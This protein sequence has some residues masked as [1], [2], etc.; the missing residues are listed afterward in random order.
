MSEAWHQHMQNLTWWEQIDRF[1][2][3]SKYTCSTF[4]TTFFLDLFPI[5][6]FFVVFAV[7]LAW[8]FWKEDEKDEY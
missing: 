8:F 5:M 1:F 7:L 3:P 2:F 6:L 4:D